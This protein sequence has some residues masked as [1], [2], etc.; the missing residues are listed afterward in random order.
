MRG[1]KNLHLLVLL[2]TDWYQALFLSPLSNPYKSSIPFLTYKDTFPSSFFI[3]TGKCF[4][5]LNTFNIILILRLTDS[6]GYVMLLIIS[7][8][9]DE[10]EM[11]AILEFWPTIQEI[12]YC[13]V[14]N[15][16]VQVTVQRL[17]A[18]ASTI[19]I[20]SKSVFFSISSILSSIN[21]EFNW[22]SIPTRF[23]W[24]GIYSILLTK[25]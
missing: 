15:L 22:L 19:H 16:I 4:L 25:K 12:S 3:H 10:D 14:K 5:L 24:R 18:S 2:M 9:E 13:S 1:W 23:E 20:I 17:K 21:T 7:W 8:A 6:F 11:V